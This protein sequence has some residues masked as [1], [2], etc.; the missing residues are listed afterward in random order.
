M[1]KKKSKKSS[2]KSK[3]PIAILSRGDERKSVSIRKAVNGFIVSMDKST[4]NGFIEKTMIE[5]TKN[6]AKEIASK[7]L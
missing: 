3:S 7:M 2:S 5:K 1:A 6:E 4:K